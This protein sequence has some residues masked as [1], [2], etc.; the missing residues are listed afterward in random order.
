MPSKEYQEGADA[1]RMGIAVA[2]NPYTRGDGLAW[3]AGWTE[4][5]YEDSG[6]AGR[7]KNDKNN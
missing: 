1:F 3:A 2:C 5:F 7:G 6:K 4:T